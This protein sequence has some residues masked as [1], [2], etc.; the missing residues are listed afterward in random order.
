MADEMEKLAG[1]WGVYNP[2]TKKVMRGLFRTKDGKIINSDIN[3][4]YNILRKAFP[5]AIMADGIEGLGLVPYSLK[6]R[7]LNQLDN[8]NIS[9]EALS[10][11]EKVDEMSQGVVRFTRN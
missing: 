1:Q 8:L 3:G 11:T 5:E 4:A 7:E 10:K 9:A 6:F 2:E